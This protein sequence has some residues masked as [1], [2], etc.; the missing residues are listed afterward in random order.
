MLYRIDPLRSLGVLLLLG[1]GMFVA[2]RFAGLGIGPRQPS[3]LG[4]SAVCGRRRFALRGML[5]MTGIGF[6]SGVVGGLTEDALGESALVVVLRAIFT[7]G[8]APAA[9]LQELQRAL[10][11][12]DVASRFLVELLGLLG[13]AL[14][15]LAWYL[16][17]LGLAELIGWLRQ[18]RP[19]G[20]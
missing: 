11:T 20:S 5:W 16:V 17:F 3:E 4:V 6:L 1:A 10:L 2:L 15:P 14:I 12:Y 19:H 18:R 13:V 9:A 8:W 7:V